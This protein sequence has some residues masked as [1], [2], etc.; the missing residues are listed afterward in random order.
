MALNR[1]PPMRVQG[2][3]EL[4]Y[5]GFRGEVPYELQGDLSRLRGMARLRGS[6]DVG[7]DLARQAFEAGEGV[8][9]LEDGVVLRITM[10]AHSRGSP[11]AYFEAR[12]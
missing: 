10:L 2:A 6:F 3:G 4:R 9:T 11:I 1:K 8:L 12:R 5:S 7:E